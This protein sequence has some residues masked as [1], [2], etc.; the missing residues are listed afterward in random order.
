M[1]LFSELKRRKVV[2]VGLAYLVAAWVVIQV[3]TTVAPQLGIPDW[4][5]RL[6]TLLVLLGFPVALV[7]SWI[8]DVTPEGIRT[9]RSA[10]GNRAIIGVGLVLAAAAVGW[11]WK[12]RPAATGDAG[13]ARSIAV[14][15]F[16]NMSGDPSREYFSDGISEEILNVLARSP[17][18][19]VAARTSSFAFKG[20]SREIPDI[21][22]E[23]N[24]RTVL[25]GSV[26][27]DGQRVRITAQLV[28]ARSGY[29]LWSQTY[30]RQMTDI[31]AVQDEI[32]QAIGRQLQVRIAGD[33]PAAAADS[34]PIAS[35]AAHDLYLRGLAKWRTRT[36]DSLWAA[37]ADFDSAAA[38]DPGFARA[39]AGLA[40]AYAIIPDYSRRIPVEDAYGR[41]KDAGEHALALD[42]KLPE[43][44][45]ALGNIAVV[46]GRVETALA[47][48]RRAV[49]LSPSFATAQ[50]WLGT[51][52][53]VQGRIDEGLAALERA[54]EL[55]PRSSVVAANH[56]IMLM[57]AARN[58]E[59]ISIL[60]DCL[61]ADPAS[62][63]CLRTK[64]MA[65]IIEDGP[66]GAR[67]VLAA[68]GNAIGREP[69]EDEEQ[70]LDAIGGRGD[71]RAAAL[72]IASDSMRLVPDPTT[73]TLFTIFEVPT[74]LILL[75]EPGLALDYL[76]RLAVAEPTEE[77]W[78]M[79]FPALDPIRCDP[80]FQA[81]AARV[82]YV[83]ARAPKVCAGPSPRSSS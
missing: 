66:D 79:V 30:D 52:L 17:G 29:H 74:L 4:A 10:G 56:A 77:S 32:A 6:V 22:R 45:A 1:T 63:L 44:F 58:A 67:P 7:L 5:P 9:D 11:Y 39:W 21:A 53:V 61:A 70:I 40:L 19:E 73:G 26:R 64:A 68:W 83:D 13:G 49:A 47:L 76:E 82:H 27:Q 75:A 33:Q 34:T 25:E 72:R 18:L 54:S 42:P 48:L 28:D 31:F 71:R 55:D 60:D 2:K 35:P 62:P 50:Q 16:V 14:L 81:V 41:G 8:F 80:R 24:V 78:S 57:A 38:T 15:P 43:A 23:L 69:N 51:S 59:A 20:Q 12:G 46:E 3:V 37:V 36:A 65:R